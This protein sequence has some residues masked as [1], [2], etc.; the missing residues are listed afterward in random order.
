MLEPQQDSLDVPMDV[1]IKST[2]E[3]RR[4][5]L[6]AIEAGDG[7]AKLNFTIKNIAVAPPPGGYSQ[8][9]S[10]GGY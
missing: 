8:G 4:E 5:R 9:G 7:N 2:E 10:Q 6:A 1:F 3:A